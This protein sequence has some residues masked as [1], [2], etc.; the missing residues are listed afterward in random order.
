MF[1]EQKNLYGNCHIDGI[2]KTMENFWK[3]AGEI[4]DELGE[5]SEYLSIVLNSIGSAYASNAT[6][7]G[8]NM[9]SEL[10][11]VASSACG[12]V[13]DRKS[14][15]LYNEIKK[16]VDQHPNNYLELNT[17]AELYTSQTI[18]NYLKDIV[19]SFKEELVSDSIDYNMPD[20][21]ITSERFE[22]IKEIIGGEKA[23]RLE[24]AIDEA[25][26]LCPVSLIFVQSLITR[27]AEGLCF[28]D[29]QT[30][31]QIFQLILDK[32]SKNTTEIQNE[33]NKVSE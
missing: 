8:E 7:T 12:S 11:V 9:Y 10:L 4:R 3:I 16:Y 20:Y 25:F 26:L 13:V 19:D 33:D 17:K 23:E 5:K 22:Q 32:K 6:F 29:P 1:E 24:G 28:R 15:E 2:K 27:L 18:L 21:A 14:H 31:K 30:S